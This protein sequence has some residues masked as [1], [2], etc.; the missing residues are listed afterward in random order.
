MSPNRNGL[1]D[2]DLGQAIPATIACSKATPKSN[3]KILNQNARTT[4]LGT[5]RGILYLLCNA[6]RK[7]Y[8]KTYR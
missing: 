7:D 4:R 3:A 8:Y 2:S 5:N 6:F 1:K